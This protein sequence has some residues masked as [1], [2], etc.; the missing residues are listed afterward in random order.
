MTRLSLV[1]VLRGLAA[2]GLAL[3]SFACYDLGDIGGAPFKCAADYPDCP[4]GYHC[5]NE[6]LCLKN[7]G[8][9]LDIPKT[10]SWQGDTEDNGLDPN[11]CPE[12]PLH[13][14]FEDAMPLGT[15]ASSWA[16]CPKGDIDVYSG[17]GSGPVK[18]TITYEVVMGDLDVGFVSPETGL[19]SVY[20]GSAKNN[21]CVV[22]NQTSGP[23]WVA[24]IGA[25]NKLTNSYAIKMET[26]KDLKCP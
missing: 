9:W 7:S 20:D 10:E 8:S 17:S 15:A 24:V 18:I 2:A 5:D 21:G 19:P 22:N 4:D 3:A 14:G 11:H 16:I 25:H 23:F 26:G 1:F 13:S 12:E 6:R